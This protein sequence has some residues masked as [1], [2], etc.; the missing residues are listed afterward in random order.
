MLSK[1][2]LKGFILYFLPIIT[3][4]TSSLIG[5]DILLIKI[6]SRQVCWIIEIA[7]VICLLYFFRSKF[8]EPLCNIFELE[9]K[10]Y[11]YLSMPLMLWG[12]VSVYQNIFYIRKNLVLNAV[13]FF[14]F[15]FYVLLRENSG[16]TL[17]FF[18]NHKIYKI[19]AGGLSII[20]AGTNII[21]YLI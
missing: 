8:I 7:L 12:I 13:I 11:K 14:I 2:W 6:F 18:P 10:L 4:V 15:G 20:I 21:M 3:L 1:N 19:V 9:K 17:G 16:L 5:L